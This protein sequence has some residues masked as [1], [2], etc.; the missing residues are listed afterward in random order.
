VN[1][2]PVFHGLQAHCPFGRKTLKQRRDFFIRCA[3]FSVASLALAITCISASAQQPTSPPADSNL[4]DSV[5]ELR[6][7]VQELRSAVADMKS[8]AAQYRAESAELRK[9]L[10]SLR[11]SPPANQ[12]QA[13]EATPPGGAAAPLDQRVGSLEETTQLLQSELRSQYQTKVESGSKYRVRLSGMALLNLFHNSG[14]VDNLD[15]PTYS[16]PH[17]P[18][19]PNSSFGATLRQSE[20]GLEVFGPELAGAKTRAEIQLDFGGG[21]PSAALDGINTGLVRLRTANMRLDWAHTSLIVGQDNLFISPLSPTSFA[22]L[23]IPSLGYSGN[24]WAWTPQLRIEHKFDLSDGQNVIVQG[25]ILDNVTGE[26]SYGSHRMPQAGE[27]SGQPAYAARIGWSKDL[28]GRPISFGTSGYYSRQNWGFD[29]NVNGWA[30]TADWRVPIASRVE[31]SGE[32]YRGRAVGGLGGGIGQSILY[33]GNPLD[34]ASD[35]RGVNSAGGWSQI[36]FSA[37]SRLEFNGAF[38]VD[39][40]YSA[41]IHAFASPVGY[42]PAVLTANRSAMMNFIYRPRSDLLLSA[43]YRHLRTSEIGTLNTADQ[44]NL[45]MGVLF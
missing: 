45:I 21:F 27:L 32:F 25:G 35:F 19:G 16:L 7:Q 17:S 30:T 26:P 31:I 23:A 22:S 44:V 37:T 38:G 34:P 1:P 36:K 3:G 14:L 11:A 20:I 15:F 18:Y 9:E 4:A 41:D 13:V 29:W 42:Y 40:P 33:S 6:E 10:E 39:D 2:I 5:K 12:N 28:N 43:E 24:L 8:E